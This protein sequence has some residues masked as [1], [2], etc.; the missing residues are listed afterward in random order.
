MGKKDKKKTE[1]YLKIKNL[2]I[3]AGALKKLKLLHTSN[4]ISNK[5]CSQ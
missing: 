3:N 5:K 1:I 4:I 2:K